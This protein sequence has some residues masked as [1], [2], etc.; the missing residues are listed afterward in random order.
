MYGFCR[1]C[2]KEVEMILVEAAPEAFGTSVAELHR[3]L[4]NSVDHFTEIGTCVWVCQAWLS[5]VEEPAD[6]A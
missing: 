4:A 2:G 5:S 6:G 3:R 1:G